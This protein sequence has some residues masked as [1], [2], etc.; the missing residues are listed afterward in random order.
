[1]ASV[2]PGALDSLNPGTTTG[3]NRALASGHGEHH[4]DLAAAIEAVQ[5]E[6]GTN[7]SGTAPTVAEAIVLANRRNGNFRHV[8]EFPGSTPGARLKAAFSAA[9]AISGTKWSLML[10][11]GDTYDVGS[12]PAEIPE[13]MSVFACFGTTTESASGPGVVNV[14]HS[15]AAEATAGVFRPAADAGFWSLNHISFQ[16]DANTKLFCDE[17]FDNS[18]RRWKYS[19]LH[20]VCVNMF[21]RIYW[22][23]HLGSTIY[24][25]T[26][27]NNFSDNPWYPVGSDNQWFGNGLFYELGNIVPASTRNNLYLIRTGTLSNTDFGPIYTTGS[28]ATVFR[29]DSTT[30][31][32]GGLRFAGGIHEGRPAHGGS[33]WCAGSLMYING[34][35]VDIRAREHGY[36][37]R[38]PSAV[39]GYTPR[40]FYTITGNAQV[41]IDGG[42]IAY[43][44]PAEYPA[45]TYSTAGTVPPFAFVGAGAKLKVENL[46]LGPNCPASPTIVVQAGGS[47]KDPD[48]I[49]TVQNVA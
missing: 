42:T 34:N 25:T 13:G 40:G 31:A 10:Q 9:G 39:T 16:G 14:R 33:L 26:Y 22:G 4:Q 36:A 47:L 28:P 27:W 8:D 1:M 18:G 43:Y 2:Y 38:N 19:T 37:M 29:Q 48:G 49:F 11:P 41:V 30:N 23:P 7:P 6:L 15:G 21:K 17:P 12:S 32:T 3:N 24:G 20:N 44:P 46:T 35:K 45:S 5:A